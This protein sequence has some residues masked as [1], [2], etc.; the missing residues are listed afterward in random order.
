MMKKVKVKVLQ[1]I[2]WFKV[3]DE[4]FMLEGNLKYFVW[5]VEVIEET[6]KKWIKKARNKAILENKES[7]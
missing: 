5:K 2:N 6:E 4:L 1:D 7:K 3:W